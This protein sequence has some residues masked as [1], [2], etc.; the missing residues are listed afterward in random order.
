MPRITHHRRTG[1]LR[2]FANA[3]VTKPFD[4]KLPFSLEHSDVLG[5]LIERDTV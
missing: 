5:V 2:I 1:P 3:S 4:G